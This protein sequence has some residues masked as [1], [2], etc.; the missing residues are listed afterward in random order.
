VGPVFQG[1]DVRIG[2][3]G[4]ILVRGPVVMK[5]YWQKPGATEAVL[6][7]GWFHTGDIGELD[8]DG[9][10]KITDRKKDL[11]VTSGGKK[12]AP[13]PIEAALKASPR[14]QEALLVG[15]GEK[16]VSALI[17][18]APEASR[19][20]VAADIERVNAGLAPFERIKKFDFIPDDLTVESGMMTPSLKLRRKS[21]VERHR[22]LVAR[23]Y[24]EEK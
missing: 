15:D 22:A 3:D 17:V 14:I 8:A 10:L 16:F 6:K 1:V 24:H 7:D 9:F 23:F 18:T 20:E 12:V 21:V 5:G 19:E 4:E 13:Q 11:L 2:D